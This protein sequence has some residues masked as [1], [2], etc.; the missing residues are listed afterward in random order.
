MIDWRSLR[1]TLVA[2]LALAAAGAA[3]AVLGKASTAV[4]G[5]LVGI[6]AL[7][8]AVA[9]NVRVEM[10]RRRGG[11]LASPEPVLS[12]ADMRL[13]VVEARQW[14]APQRGKSSEA[15][16]EDAVQVRGAAI[17][18]GWRVEG[19]EAGHPVP[20]GNGLKLMSPPMKGY[21]L[22]LILALPLN[23]ENVNETARHVRAGG[24]PISH[25]DRNP[26]A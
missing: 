2:A 1:T 14:L 6:L 15:L 23:R 5:I 7:V 12:E 10:L 13:A 4:W 25:I 19:E 8:V 18:A 26:R 24:A 17:C 22:E 16:L 9:A 3:V 11:D 20:D 21:A